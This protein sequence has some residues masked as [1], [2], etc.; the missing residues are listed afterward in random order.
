V[1]SL[2]LYHWQLSTRGGKGRKKKQT[3][4]GKV[5][6]DREKRKIE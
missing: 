5:K 1:C 6:L 3:P 2:L 4:P